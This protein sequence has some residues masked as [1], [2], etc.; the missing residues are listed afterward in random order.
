MNIEVVPGTHESP[1]A[2][3]LALGVAGIAID[4]IASGL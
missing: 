4:P 2:L 1:A 3:M